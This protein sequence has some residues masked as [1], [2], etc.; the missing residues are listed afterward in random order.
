M[1]RSIHNYNEMGV[2]RDGE[3]DGTDGWGER[4]ERGGESD[5]DREREREK[6]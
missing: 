5:K 6:K 1:E 4:S 2:D 3:L